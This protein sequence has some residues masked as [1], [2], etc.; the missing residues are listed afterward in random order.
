M[1]YLSSLD[2]C[3]A[4]Y[5][6]ASSADASY[7][8]THKGLVIGGSL[9]LLSLLVLLP[10]LYLCWRRRRA[11]GASRQNSSDD[12][13][14]FLYGPASDGSTRPGGYASPPVPLLG[15]GL[16]GDAEATAQPGSDP[17][18][19]LGEELQLQGFRGGTAR[20]PSDVELHI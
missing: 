2:Q 11:A 6:V 12:A 18:E 5:P 17:G 15:F 3:A 1:T 16:G 10:V 19:G 9:G 8:E 14:E 13:E 4:V 20:A 7:F